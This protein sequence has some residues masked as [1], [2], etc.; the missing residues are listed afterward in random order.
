MKYINFDIPANEITQYIKR[1]AV[2]SE[3]TTEYLIVSVLSIIFRVYL[4][5]IINIINSA[6]TIIVILS[7]IKLFMGN[8]INPFTKVIPYKLFFNACVIF[9]SPHIRHC[10]SNCIS[11]EIVSA[12]N[13]LN[14]NVTVIKV[15]PHLIHTGIFNCIFPV[16]LSM[17][18]KIP[19]NI[20]HKMYVQLHHA[21]FQI[22]KKQSKYFAILYS[23]L[24]YCLL[25]GYKYI[26]LKIW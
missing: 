7:S 20:P 26:L 4:H 1:N 24:L 23:S 6:H 13:R 18:S 25:M 14:N 16:I 17:T 10:D 12:L 19:C 8:C 22:Q 3:L 21:I 5:I 9:P 11:S 2:N 15:I